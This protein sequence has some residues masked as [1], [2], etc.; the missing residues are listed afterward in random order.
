MEF[1][2]AG[3]CPRCGRPLKKA[4]LP[5]KHT[6]LMACK[7]ELEERRNDEESR[8]NFEESL[9][10]NNAK[11]EFLQTVGLRYRDKTLAN[12][13]RD[14]KDRDKKHLLLIHAMA[15]KFD[16][17]LKEGVGGLVAGSY[18][19]G[20]THLEV[21]LGLEL[22]E[23]G[24]SVRMYDSSALYMEYMA[25]FSWN[26]K[27]QPLDVIRKA[28]DSDL[29]ILDDLGVNTVDSDKDNFVK[30]IYALINY[31]YNQKK[32]ILISTNLKREELAAAVTMRVADR[33]SA[34]TYY[35]VNGCPSKRGKE[36]SC[37]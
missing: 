15:K 4:V 7:C 2:E 9:N 8:K 6:I 27:I 19:C 24:Y 23:K 29:L 35:V 5:N 28:C 36:L 17:F 33:I 13:K 12:Y 25:A 1:K 10:R 20:K 22:I 30:F 14:P 3:K 34:M 26:Q 11:K 31:R 21:A 32:P 37:L 16:S 18:G